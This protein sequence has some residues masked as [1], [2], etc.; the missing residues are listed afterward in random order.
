MNFTEHNYDGKNAIGNNYAGKNA[1]V[2]YPSFEET[3]LSISRQNKV[4][5]H[6]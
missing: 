3:E 1:M 4:Q 6:N 2:T 5:N